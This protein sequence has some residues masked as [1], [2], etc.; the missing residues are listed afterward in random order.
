MEKIARLDDAF[1]EVFLTTSK[2]RRRPITAAKRKEKEKK[3]RE[4]KIE[5][6]KDVG[7]FLVQNFD[8]CPCLSQ[9]VRKCDASGK[10]GKQ[11]CC[12]MHFRPD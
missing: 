9:N 8:F 2:P 12:K 1:S 5:K 10:K 7:H 3:E 6:P 4:K 11:S